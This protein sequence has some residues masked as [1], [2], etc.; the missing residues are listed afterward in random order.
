MFYVFVPGSNRHPS[1]IY[2][3]WESADVEARRL[4]SKEGVAEAFVCQVV[5]VTTSK[6]EVLTPDRWKKRRMGV[7]ETMVSLDEVM[8]LVEQVKNSK[9]RGRP[10]KKVLKVETDIGSEDLDTDLPF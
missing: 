8:A 7:P 1:Y 10:K 5:S 3:T 6:V 9:K 2:D 4:V